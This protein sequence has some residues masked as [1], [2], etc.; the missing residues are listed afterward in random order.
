MILLCK[1]DGTIQNQQ[2][3]QCVLKI[4]DVVFLLQLNE[5]ISSPGEGL[6]WQV[7]H[8]QPVSG[9]GGQ[10]SLDNLQTLCTVCHREVSDA[11]RHTWLRPKTA[12]WKL[13]VHVWRVTQ[14]AVSPGLGSEMCFILFM[15]YH[16]SF[17]L[18]SM[19]VLSHRWKRNCFPFN[20]F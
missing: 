10:C 2:S 3:P 1:H 15:T 12:R 8:I 19:Q 14:V 4:A 20:L 18:R 13:C 6:F 17:F 7:D 16:W 11:C 5:M 9:G